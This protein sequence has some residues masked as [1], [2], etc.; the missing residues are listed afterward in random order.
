MSLSEVGQLL[1]VLSRSLCPRA[2]QSA[3]H[4]ELRA[5]DTVQIAIDVRDD[6]VEVVSQRNDLGHS[7]RVLRDG[8]WGFAVSH[9]SKG[10]ES[11]VTE[12]STVARVIGA[13]EG[14]SGVELADVRP[15]KKSVPCRL[16]TPLCEVSEADK[17]SFLQSVCAQARKMDS[18]ISTVRASYREIVGKRYLVTSEGTESEIEVSSAYLMCTASGAEGPTVGTARD[19]VARACT[20]WELFDRAEPPEKISERLVT[21]VR[22]QLDGVACRRGSFPCVLGPRVVGMLAHEALGHLSEADYYASGAFA[23]KEGKPIAPEKVTM[24]DSPRIRDG[25]GNI[26]IDDEGVLPTKV[27]LIERG[28]LKDK[29]TNREWAARLGCRP[30][31]SA[32]AETYRVPPI[33]RMRNTYFEKGDMSLEELLEGVKRGYYCGDVRGGQAEAN[34]SFQVAVQDCYEI[35]G[36]EI[37][38]PVRNLAISGLAIRSLKLID[39][40]GKD[41]GIESSYCGKSDQYM[42]TS[43]GGPH[44]SFLRGGIIF[45]G[46]E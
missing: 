29:M 24:V 4:I 31:G 6:R 9:G 10:I 8:A 35:S 44:M 1:D 41:F 5:D 15:Q 30:T 37:G 27:T 26:E 33:I 18:R 14:G 28:K 11:T 36:G 21:K 22:G 20:G 17:L 23:G 32:R 3:S 25:F 42:A 13:R 34:S 38:R 2:A 7:A 46:D 45:G 39:G 43:D 19:E 40:L 12:A 16:H